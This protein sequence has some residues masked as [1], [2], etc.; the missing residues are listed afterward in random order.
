[1]RFI[2]RKCTRFPNY[3]GINL[4]IWARGQN[5]SCTVVV[6]RECDSIQPLGL[7]QEVTVILDYKNSPFV[8]G[9]LFSLLCN[10]QEHG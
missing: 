8:D 2:V 9:A 3:P 4:I 10:A 7:T 1:M 5:S 6:M